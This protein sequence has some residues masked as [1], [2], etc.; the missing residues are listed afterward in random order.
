MN[1]LEYDLFYSNFQVYSAVHWFVHILF[2]SVI[3]LGSVVPVIIPKS[4]G[5]DKEATQNTQK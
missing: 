1:V 2:V 5:K 4:S 3:V